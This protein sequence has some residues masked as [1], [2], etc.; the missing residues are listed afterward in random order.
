MDLRPNIEIIASDN[1]DT[2]LIAVA[3]FVI[4]TAVAIPL[5]TG[6][7][8]LKLTDLPGLVKVTA[9]LRSVEE[10][11]SMDVITPALP[12]LDTADVS[13]QMAKD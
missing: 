4:I 6:N 9:H 7:L 3:V 13:G 2:K 11:G 1:T 8:L 10:E 12:L 5:T